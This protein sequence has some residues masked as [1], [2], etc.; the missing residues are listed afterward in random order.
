MT[1][2][3]DKQS[4]MY[5]TGDLCRYLPDGNL[6]FSTTRSSSQDRGYARLGEIESEIARLPEVREAAVVASE[7]GVGARLIAYAVT[8]PLP[9]AEP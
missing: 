9:F 4:L 5:R 6:N 8:Q 1:D 2:P 7:E 3:W